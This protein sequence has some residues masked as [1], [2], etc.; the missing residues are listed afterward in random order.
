MREGD[1]QDRTG[2][3]ELF[4]NHIQAKVQTLHSLLEAKF[5]KPLPRWAAKRIQE[6][7][8]RQHDKWL[9]LLLKA[10]TL[11]AVVGKRQPGKR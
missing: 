10:D 2:I 7:K 3:D 4:P 5:G 6:A 1:C 9:L 11:E 8:P